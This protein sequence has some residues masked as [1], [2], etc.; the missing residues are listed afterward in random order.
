M[1]SLNKLR[2]IAVYPVLL[3]FP[4]QS[5]LEK[6]I[7]TDSWSELLLTCYCKDVIK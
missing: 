6:I 5:M 2:K 1:T 7:V 4:N 3:A